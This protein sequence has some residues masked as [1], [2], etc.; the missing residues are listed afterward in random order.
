MN[1]FFKTWSS[2]NENLSEKKPLFLDSKIAPSAVNIEF[3]DKVNMSNT[4][5]YTKYVFQLNYLLLICYQLKYLITKIGIC[6]T[7]IFS[8]AVRQR[9]SQVSI[10][11]AAE[12]V[13]VDLKKVVF[14]LYST[15][16]KTA[17][18]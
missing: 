4:C 13:C 8:Q 12:L 14:D 17:K 10:I 9:Y 3:Y 2:R 5:S 6:Q 16:I 1:S 7:E 11:R 15:L 18:K